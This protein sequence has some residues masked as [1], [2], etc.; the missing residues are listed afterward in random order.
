MTAPAARINIQFVDDRGQH[1]YLMNGQVRPS[2]TTILEAEGLSGCPFWTEDA[3]KRGT[4][5]HRIAHLIGKRPIRGRTVE[6]VVANSLWDP[7]GTA[8]VLVPYGMACAKFYL[9]SKLR[10][11]LAEQ[12]LGSALFDFC[13]TTDLYAETPNGK[14]VVV[15]FKSGQPE[16]A[17]HVQTALYEIGLNETFG[18]LADERMVVWLKPD[19][20][21]RIVRP[22]LDPA[23]Y[24]NAG[25]CAVNLYHWR[26]RFKKLG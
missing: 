5:V 18:L 6:D 12:P 4:A 20:D 14:R 11:I 24:V 23:V 2:V 13:G 9:E 25:K 8:P 7:G 22:K 15:D 17:A 19:G 3:R 21:Y 1:Q 10:T 16:E 26:Q